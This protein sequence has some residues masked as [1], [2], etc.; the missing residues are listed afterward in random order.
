MDEGEIVK[1]SILWLKDYQN[2]MSVKNG[3]RKC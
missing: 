1:T 2:N 3:G